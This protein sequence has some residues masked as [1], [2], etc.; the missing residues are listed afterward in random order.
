MDQTIHY[1]MTLRNR[2]VLAKSIEMMGHLKCQKTAIF[3]DKVMVFESKS[4]QISEACQMRGRLMM[5]SKYSERYHKKFLIG[6]YI[7]F[8]RDPI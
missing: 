2:K 4:E 8:T 5:M 3:P 6:I 1:E 7:T